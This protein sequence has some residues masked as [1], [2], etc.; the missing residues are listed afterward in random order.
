MLKELLYLH[1]NDVANGVVLTLDG[2]GCSIHN[3]CIPLV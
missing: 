2:E 3:L 1:A